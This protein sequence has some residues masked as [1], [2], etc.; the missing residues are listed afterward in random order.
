MREN[1]LTFFLDAARNY[2]DLICLNDNSH[3]IYLLNHPDYIKYVLQDNYH[4]YI[5]NEDSL[6]LLV[7]NGIGVSDGDFWLRQ[8]RIMQPSFHRQRLAAMFPIMRNVT[9]SFLEHWR[10]SAKRGEALDIL[11]EMTQLTF[12]LS[13][14][15]MFS[16]D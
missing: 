11:T 10:T 4:N 1:P 3:K 14:R 6:K 2:G 12:D 7:G 8:R 15:T 5:R 13:A 16:A 9:S